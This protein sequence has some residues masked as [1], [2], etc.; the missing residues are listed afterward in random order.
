M[1]TGH[2]RK[3]N[4][5]PAGAGLYSSPST[6]L[7]TSTA[8]FSAAVEPWIRAT[9]FRPHDL[10]AM[11]ISGTLGSAFLDHLH[12]S[13]RP[14]SAGCRTAFRAGSLSAAA[15]ILWSL[16]TAPP[17]WRSTFAHAFCDPRYSSASVRAA[18]DRLR[19]RFW[20]IFFRSEDARTVFWRSFARRFRSGARLAMSSAGL[21]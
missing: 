17:G 15:V 16:A 4:R 8:R 18:T 20:R 21:I 9:F 12:A 3:R 6:C 11:A 14:L 10:N 13:V 1:T 7:T 2:Q 19:R 5:A